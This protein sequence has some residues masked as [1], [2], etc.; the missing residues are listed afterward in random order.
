MLHTQ[1]WFA[2]L[3]LTCE[4]VLN[5][6]EVGEADQAPSDEVKSHLRCW[7][8]KLWLLLCSSTPRGMWLSENTRTP[9]RMEQQLIITNLVPINGGNWASNQS[10]ASPAHSITHPRPTTLEGLKSRR[11]MF[12]DEEYLRIYEVYERAQTICSNGGAKF[13]FH[14]NIEV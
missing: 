13:F 9:N 6:H 5:L 10:L 8:G 2:C 7:A 14:R 11:F 12:T 3:D 1:N 4:T